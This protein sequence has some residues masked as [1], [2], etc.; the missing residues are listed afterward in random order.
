MDDDKNIQ[1]YKI[2]RFFAILRTRSWY[3]SF[4]KSLE[5][6]FGKPVL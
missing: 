6:T 5:N 3:A 1:I 2:I 4:A